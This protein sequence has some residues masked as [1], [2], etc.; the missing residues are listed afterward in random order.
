M[1]KTHSLDDGRGGKTVLFPVLWSV[2]KDGRA[3]PVGKIRGRKHHDHWSGI[4]GR[5]P[6]E[7]AFGLGC[8]GL[9]PPAGKCD[10]ADLFALYLFVVSALSPGDGFV[11]CAAPQRGALRPFSGC[12]KMMEK[13]VR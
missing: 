1:E 12:G 5:M 9:F 2:R 4:F 7:P 11:R 6:D 10:G 8:V 3:Q 13:N